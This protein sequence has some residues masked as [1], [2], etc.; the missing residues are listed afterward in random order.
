MDNVEALL[1]GNLEPKGFKG[2]LT[3][4]AT[5]TTQ[6][7]ATSVCAGLGR[8]PE[9]VAAQ[10]DQIAATLRL[11][12]AQAFPIGPDKEY[13]KTL[14][15]AISTLNEAREKRLEQAR[16]AKEPAAQA[17][18]LGSLAESF[19]KAAQGLRRARVS[20]AAEPANAAIVDALQAGSAAYAAIADGGE[21]RQRGG[22]RAAR[23]RAGR[24]DAELQ[25][26]LRKLEALGYE[27]K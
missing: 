23:A 22:V 15:Q 25:R 5:P 27:V 26:A 16:E 2:E 24:A 20:P 12:G 13:A 18:A 3:V 8:F 17:A 21:V 14:N 9:T 11:I 19:G 4:F 1:Y 6:G 7:V 10:C